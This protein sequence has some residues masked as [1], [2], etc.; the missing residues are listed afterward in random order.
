[1]NRV[2]A[3]D[4]LLPTCLALARDMLS[5]D[6]KTMRAYK[7]LIDRGFG[8]PLAEGIAM[9]REASREHVRR[10]SAADV[11][12]RRRAIQERGRSQGGS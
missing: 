6:P 8:L 12:A 7:A 3:P 5:C 1:V 10:V 4:D 9:E 2:V 11:A